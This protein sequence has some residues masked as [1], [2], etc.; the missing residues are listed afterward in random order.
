MRQIRDENPITTISPKTWDQVIYATR[1][2]N[3]EITGWLTVAR[4]ENEFHISG[5]LIIPKQEV[6]VAS[7][8]VD[9]VDMALM[10]DKHEGLNCWWHSHVNMETSPSS[11]DEEQ[12]LGYADDT[13]F[14]LMLITNKSGGFSLEVWDMETNLVWDDVPLLVGGDHDCSWLDK[15]IKANVGQKK[16]IYTTGWAAPNHAGPLP[17]YNWGRE[18][19][20]WTP[21]ADQPMSTWKEA[22]EQNDKAEALAQ[23]MMEKDA[24]LPYYEAIDTA[25]EIVD[26]MELSMDEARFINRNHG[27][28]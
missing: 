25:Y 13:P 19:T 6:S 5:D 1:A 18:Q 26:S 7:I 8:D 2:V 24:E 22:A 20:V 14:Y 16:Y 10:F 23:G 4:D 9:A 28:S 27:D 21:C 12:M 15:P 11:T 17:S 3:T